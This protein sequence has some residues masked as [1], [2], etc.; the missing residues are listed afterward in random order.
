[1]VT[2]SDDDVQ[3]LIETAFNEG[4]WAGDAA[5]ESK[6]SVADT[7]QRALARFTAGHRY[8]TDSLTRPARPTEGR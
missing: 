7:R 5:H 4:F 8:G 6:E 1:M 2:M 3:E